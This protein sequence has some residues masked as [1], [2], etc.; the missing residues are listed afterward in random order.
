[1]ADQKII[2]L[3][4]NIPRYIIGR[5]GKQNVA[6]TGE[7]RIVPGITEPFEFMVANSDGVD[8]NLAGFKLLIL[9]YYQQ[10]HYDSLAANL[11]DNIILAK[12]LTVDDPY[13]GN[14]TLVLSDQETITLAKTGR[15]TLRWAIYMINE[16]NQKFAMQ[17]TNDGQKFGILHIDR[18]EIPTSE[19]IDGITISK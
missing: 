13:S 1:M 5:P 10:A 8:L 2:N 18:S 14:A 17:I 7:M 4:Y 9:F 12:Y 16:Q 15:R 19:T 11:G 6:C 3:Q